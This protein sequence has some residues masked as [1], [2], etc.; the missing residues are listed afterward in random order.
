[1]KIKVVH[2]VM[3]LWP[4]G[5]EIWLLRLLQSMDRER[6]EFHIIVQK[7]E[8]S[9][10][11]VE[12]ESLGVKVHRCLGAPNPIHFTL[13]FYKTLALIGNVDVIH[14]HVHHFSGFILFLA[15]L[16]RIPIR[17]SHCHNDTRTLRK[18]DA[19]SR[20]LYNYFME[21]LINVFSTKKLAVSKFA[22]SDLYNNAT[23]YKF[24]PCGID[25]NEF[26]RTT[27][28]KEMLLKEFNFL[29]EKKLILHIGRFTLQKNHNFAIEVFNEILKIYPD[30]I[31]VLVGTGEL[32]NTIK[33][34][35][36]ALNLENDVILLGVRRDIPDLLRIADTFLFPS[37]HEGLGVSLV[38]A[39]AAGL[40]CVISDTIPTEAIVIPELVVCL[41]L[42]EDVIIWRDAVIRSLNKEKYNQQSAFAQIEAS[43]FCINQNVV[44]LNQYYRVT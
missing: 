24:L 35:I 1:M 16:K 34:K 13:N 21:N 20:K 7:S 42:K 30:T 41:S 28:Q 3:T 8:K 2:F 23:D 43:A 18:N 40:R 44:L 6:F 38:E 15:W 12:F 26:L 5:V 14:S 29:S 22:A 37:F 19:I 25:L 9:D 32:F 27:E 31:L 11:E 39:Q 33:S 17:I 36:S 10:L 4:A